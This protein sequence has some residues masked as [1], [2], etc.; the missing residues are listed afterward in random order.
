MFGEKLFPDSGVVRI[1]CSESVPE[2]SVAVLDSYDAA[3]QTWT[4]IKPDEDGIASGRI[5]F[6]Q[7]PVGA[8]QVGVG[9]L[10]NVH[11]VKQDD[12]DSESLAVGDLCS[13]KEDSWYVIKDESGS[14][15]VVDI[16]DSGFLLAKNGGGGGNAQLVVAEV[17]DDSFSYKIGFSELE[18]IDTPGGHPDDSWDWILQTKESGIQGYAG[19]LPRL[20]PADSSFEYVHGLKNGNTILI[21]SDGTHHIFLWR[22]IIPNGYRLLHPELIFE[23]IDVEVIP[24]IINYLGG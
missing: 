12:T 4:V 23:D 2:L 19:I 7:N 3:S 14:F 1:T 17:T 6:V 21:L 10:D 5:C 8:N 20:L 13:T 18:F 16:Y 11:V 15:V 24:G 9:F 22:I